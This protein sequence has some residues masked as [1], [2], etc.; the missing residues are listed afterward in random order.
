MDSL[1]Y[2]LPHL[3]YK[4]CKYEVVM[5]LPQQDCFPLR[6]RTGNIHSVQFQLEDA[7]AYKS[8]T[9]SSLSSKRSSR[10]CLLAQIMHLYDSNI[11]IVKPFHSNSVILTL[12]LRVY[13]KKPAEETRPA[14]LEPGLESEDAFSNIIDWN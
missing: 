3:G 11:I 10:L 14:V 7:S 8:H 4:T 2:V 1:L 12:S 6:K 9:S 5:F 13:W